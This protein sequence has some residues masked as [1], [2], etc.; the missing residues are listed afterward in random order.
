MSNP[1]IDLVRPEDF[2]AAVQQLRAFF[3]ARGFIEG[4][5][6]HRLEPLGILAACENPF[7]IATFDYAG[8]VWPLPQT[9]QMWLELE[10]L[11]NR[12]AKGYF[13]VSTSFRQE[14]EPIRGRHNLVF[15]MVEF[16]THGDMT[17]LMTFELYRAD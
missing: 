14:P 3:L 1:L 10:L 2:N 11:R 4:H 15:P 16:E 12:S 13:C 6:Q 7:T 5:F 8:Q 17:A 9:A